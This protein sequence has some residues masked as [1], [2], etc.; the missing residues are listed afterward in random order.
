MNSHSVDEGSGKTAHLHTFSGF[1]KWFS[2]SLYFD[3]SYQNGKH[4]W[5]RNAGHLHYKDTHTCTR[6]NEHCNSKS[7]DITSGAVVSRKYSP[8]AKKNGAGASLVVQ[9]LRLRTPDAGDPGS[10]PGQGTRS[11][12]PQLRARVPQLRARVPQL[13]IPHAATKTQGS[14]INK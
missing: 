6:T 8:A 2:L 13:K 4:H 5:A 9:Q 7:C 14:P 10:I 11:R 12:M 1:A 3:H